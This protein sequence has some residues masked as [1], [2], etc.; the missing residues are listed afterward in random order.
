MVHGNLE[1][2]RKCDVNITLQ[3]QWEGTNI[4]KLLEVLT[5]KRSVLYQKWVTGV[6]HELGSYYP[7]I[8]LLRVT[9]PS[10]LR[11]ERVVE[12]Q[13]NKSL[14]FTFDLRFSD[15][16]SDVEW[17]Y[18]AKPNINRPNPNRMNY[19]DNPL[20]TE[21]RVLTHRNGSWHIEETLS[22][23]NL[24]VS[25]DEVGRVFKV[26]SNSFY[27]MLEVRPVEQLPIYVRLPPNNTIK[28]L[29]R[30]QVS[31]QPLRHPLEVVASTEN[32]TMETVLQ[33]IKKGVLKLA[34]DF[35]D[36][37]NAEH[38]LREKYVDA[39]A[40][41]IGAYYLYLSGTYKKNVKWFQ[42]LANDFPHLP[43]GP[44]IYASQLINKEN[45]SKASIDLSRRYFLLSAQ[46]GLPVY[47][48]GF[49]MLREGLIKMAGYFNNQDFEVNKALLML[50]YYHRMMDYTKD[51]TTVIPM[52]AP[53]PKDQLYELY[54]VVPGGAG[55]SDYIWKSPVN[56]IFNRNVED[57]CQ[58]HNEDQLETILL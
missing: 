16:S 27:Q 11:R 30:S 45:P 6:N 29:I 21:I 3:S 7:G 19:K 17:A 44:V 10:G 5:P 13:S 35:M 50:E 20:F 51:L 55:N 22:D 23:R 34:E 14:H 31:S 54:S 36:Q 56:L 25:I 24:S 2:R 52:T 26:D 18:Y 58:E 8:Y 38:L 32:W 40:A 46:R 42:N 49:K 41:A 43:D 4:P 39:N 1:W 53:S 33:V 15:V 9:L 57:I 48:I 28:I 12:L 37:Q 47:T